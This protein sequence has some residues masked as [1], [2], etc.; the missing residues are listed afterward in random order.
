M[1]NKTITLKDINPLDDIPK[2]NQCNGNC[3]S[4]IDAPCDQSSRD[5]GSELQ[6]LLEAATSDEQK[7]II[8]KLIKHDEG[9]QAFLNDPMTGAMGAPVGDFMEDF[10]KEERVLLC[11]LLKAAQVNQNQQLIEYAAREATRNI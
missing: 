1:G 2:G 10:E 3:Q 8:K 9:V 6:Y 5:A 7:N 11:D 4:C